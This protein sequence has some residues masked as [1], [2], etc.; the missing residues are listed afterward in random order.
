MKCS[1]TLLAVRSKNTGVRKRPC[2]CSRGII[3]AFSRVAAGCR[4]FGLAN[5]PKRGKRSA[6]AAR[7]R[8]GRQGRSGALSG[9]R[10][11]R[12][13]AFST[14]Q[15]CCRAH[16]FSTN[17]IFHF[18]EKYIMWPNNPAAEPYCVQAIC[19]LPAPPPRAGSLRK[20][21][22][23]MESGQRQTRRPRR[24]QRYECFTD[25]ELA[26]ILR[27][28]RHTAELPRHPAGRR[29]CAPRIAQG[30]RVTLLSGVVVTR[31]ARAA[32]FAESA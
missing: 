28:P 19:H 24:R 2:N 26:N 1:R 8:S 22:E 13:Q 7:N 11:E 14:R 21:E 25:D 15:R 16:A 5:A 6:M 32:R 3:S 4:R 17:N 29:R 9:R 12:W 31:F 27:L 30:S 23:D 20:P 18:T 10:T